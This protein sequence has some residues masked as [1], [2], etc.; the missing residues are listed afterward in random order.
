[1]SP[2]V[3]VSDPDLGNIVN[4][5]PDLGNIVSN[6]LDLG[7]IVSNNPD[8]GNIVSNNPDRLPLS[9]CLAFRLQPATTVAT[10]TVQLCD[11]LQRQSRKQVIVVHEIGC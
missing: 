2:R 5:N 8:P 4:N 10:H 7:N 6:N 11:F 3:P 1:M 9:V